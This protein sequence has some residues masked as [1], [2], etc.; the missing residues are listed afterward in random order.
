L[1]IRGSEA[2]AVRQHRCSHA[3]EM[4]CTGPVALSVRCGSLSRRGGRMA[5]LRPTT[6]SHAIFGATRDSAHLHER[7]SRQPRL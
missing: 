3:L 6:F 2:D 5:A 1:G 7:R 4:Y